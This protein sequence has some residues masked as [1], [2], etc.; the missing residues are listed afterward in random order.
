MG[1]IQTLLYEGLMSGLAAGILMGLI[2]HIGFRVAAFKSSLLIIDGSFAL[3]KLRLQDDEKRS[4]L[5][6]IPVHL[7]TSISFGLS[8][9]VLVRV[10][11]MEPTSVWVVTGYVFMLWLAMLF[12]A[13]PI[14][15]HG[16]FGRK[17][18]PTTW[19]EQLLLHII[20]GIVL[21]YTLTLLQQ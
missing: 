9:A 19:F 2:S 13:L 3:R 10:L 14:A 17:L 6:G 21:W 7:V 16:P 20:F 15:G 4:A 8:Y 12:I 18:G 11:N 5:L 1:N